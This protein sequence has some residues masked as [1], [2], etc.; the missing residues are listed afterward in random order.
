M[1]RFENEDLAL[2]MKDDGHFHLDGTVNKATF[3]IPGSLVN[4]I[5]DHYTAQKWLF[6][7]KNGWLLRKNVGFSVHSFLKK[8][9][10]QRRLLQTAIFNCS[11]TVPFLSFA[12]EE[13]I[14]HRCG[15]DETVPLLV[16]RERPRLQFELRSLIV[17]FTIRGSR[18]SADLSMCDIYRWRYLKSCYAGKPRTLGKLKTAIRKNIQEIGEEL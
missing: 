17:S 8:E 11:K 10:R 12:D 9:K 4:Y 1:N 5:S 14:G 2:I 15:F 3:S 13:L 7:E 18:C 6:S 16:Q